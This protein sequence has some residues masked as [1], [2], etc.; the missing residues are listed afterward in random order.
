MQARRASAIWGL[1]ILLA[2]SLVGVVSFLYPFFGPSQ[3]QGAFQAA[4]H[5]QDAPLVFVVLVAL[6]VGAVVGNLGTGEMNAKT[7]A[8]LGI[9]TAVNAV[10]R[11][12]PGPA[13]FA[14]VFFLPILGGYVYGPTFGFLLG[15]LSLLVSAL[16]GAG[17]G[18]WLPYQM[19]AAGWVGLLS[20]LLP[21]RL[22]RRLGRLEPALLAVWGLVLGLIYGAVM[23]LWFWPFIFVPGQTDLYW[24]PGLGFMDTLRR[25]AVFYVATSLVW[26]LGRAGGNFLL[27]LL[28]GAPLL[29]LLRRFRQRFRFRVEVTTRRDCTPNDQTGAAVTRPVQHLVEG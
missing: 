10:L 25:Y 16:I 6:C 17:V 7:V 23:N 22:F 15:T 4:A 8:I 2:A 21:E 20:A 3:Q 18:P 12:I 26:D 29:R 5:A 27:L 14:A 28:F 13:G 11:Y 24:Q 9:L 1:L 19:F